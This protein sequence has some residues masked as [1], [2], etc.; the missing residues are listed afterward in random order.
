VVG[1]AVELDQLA[2]PIPAALFGDF[3]KT[4]Q[5]RRRDALAAILG[6]DNQVTTAR[7]HSEKLVEVDILRHG[8]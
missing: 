2:T 1:F 3:A 6:H 8:N 7:N 5:H 4:L